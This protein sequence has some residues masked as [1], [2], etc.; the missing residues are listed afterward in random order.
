MPEAV[1]VLPWFVAPLAALAAGCALLAP[2][3]H[4]VLD[5]GIVFIDL[6]VAQAAAAT[7]LWVGAWLGGHLGV[8]AW[9][10]SAAGAL[11]GSMFVAWLVRRWPPYREALIGLVY[12]AGA[13]LAVLGARLDPHGGE[14]LAQMLAA[15]VLWADMTQA[16]ALAVTAALVIALK[17]RLPRVSSGDAFFYMVFAF[18]V[19]VAVPVLGLVLVFACL[20]APALWM[21]AGWAWPFVLASAVIV[22]AAGLALSWMLDWPS[23][24][25]VA[26]GLTI[27]GLG[28]AIGRRRQQVSTYN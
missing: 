23:G 28:S 9:V 1:T 11:A 4:R 17:W 16:V 18:A 24:A 20:I 3:G 6:A 13:S 5:R 22:A 19:S 14:R 15:D 2:L 21:R 25:C 8:W 7:S 27:W 10:A 26:A 12:A